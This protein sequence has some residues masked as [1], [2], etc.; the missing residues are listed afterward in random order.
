ME[1]PIE[2][3]DGSSSEENYVFPSFPA[4]PDTPG[5]SPLA[6]LAATC[7]KIGPAASSAS[8]TSQSASPPETVSESVETA[9]LSEVVT[10]STSGQI[11]GIS[12]PMLTA[13]AAAAGGLQMLSTSPGGMPTHLVVPLTFPTAPDILSAPPQPPILVPN[14]PPAAVERSSLA[15]S[16]PLI[17][18]PHISSQEH[19]R[20]SDILNESSI[21][22]SNSMSEAASRSQLAAFAPS[23]VSSPQ[24]TPCIISNTSG[25]L[26]VLPAAV[27]QGRQQQE[28]RPQLTQQLQHSHQLPQQSQHPPK[29]QQQFRQ[30]QQLARLPQQPRGCE[31]YPS[32]TRSKGS[33]SVKPIRP[34]P[35]NKKVLVR[36]CHM[37]LAYSRAL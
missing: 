33:S 34:K 26:V 17:S 32:P 8:S 36:K 18:A 31:T 23:H 6:L 15:S 24:L 12:L 37:C 30:P 28:A 25:Q 4:P 9:P 1:R 35:A 10:A 29:V 7:S 3:Q 11:P 19:Q 27:S 5:V 13:N 21:L 16:H 2:N 22:L 14:S 20:L